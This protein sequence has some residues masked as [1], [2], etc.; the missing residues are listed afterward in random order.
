MSLANG[1]GRA[2]DGSALHVP[3]TA[4]YALQAVLERAEGRAADAE[5]KWRALEARFAAWKAETV[6][7]LEARGETA[8]LAKFRLREELDALRGGMR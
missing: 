3:V 5:A 7:G 6:A 4:V 8:L 1:N 2:D